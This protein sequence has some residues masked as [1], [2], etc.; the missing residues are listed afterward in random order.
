LSFFISLAVENVRCLE[1]E[2]Y[3]PLWLIVTNVG[4]EVLNAFAFREQY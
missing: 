1:F 4:F 2:G 3:W